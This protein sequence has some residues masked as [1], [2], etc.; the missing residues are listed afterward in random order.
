MS[1]GDFLHDDATICDIDDSA[2][3]EICPGSRCP[4]ARRLVTGKHEMPTS[5]AYYPLHDIVSGARMKQTSG[6]LVLLEPSS[7]AA[8]VIADADYMV[9]PE[10][11]CPAIVCTHLT[12]DTPFGFELVRKHPT[13][14]G[15]KATY[16]P[17]S[18]VAVILEFSDGEEI[19]A[20]GFRAVEG[21]A[22]PE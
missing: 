7:T 19:S 12:M 6:Y 22:N 11:H 5:R 10:P 14:K 8:R 15:S 2:G 4:G 3:R 18:A 17:Y 1:V 13:G 20:F 21:A 16:L 9:G